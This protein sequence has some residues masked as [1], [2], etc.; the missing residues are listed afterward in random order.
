MT[1]PETRS[2]EVGRPFEVSL[3]SNPTTGYDWQVAFPPELFRLEGRRHVRSSERIGAGG[4]TTFTFLPLAPGEGILRFRYL[5]LW[6]GQSV[7]DREV[8]VRVAPSP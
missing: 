6:E 8:R 3:P 1:E 2:A 7:D 4:T 5:R